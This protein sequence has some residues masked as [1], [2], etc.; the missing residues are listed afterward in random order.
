MEPE[1][2]I[3]IPT[4]FDS[5]YIVELALVTIRKYTTIPYK[6]V[7]GDAGVDEE[8]RDFLASQ[9]DVRVVACPDPLR[10]KD[11]LVRS[12]DTP[13]GIILHDDVQILREGWLRRRLEVMKRDPR[14]GI[15]GVLAP[16]YIYGW[17]RF[18]YRSPLYWRFFPLVMMIRREMQE[19]LDLWWGKIPGFDTGAI[20]YL[21]FLKQRKWRF[22][23]YKFNRDVLHLG[24]MTWVIRKK[25]QGEKM[26]RLDEFVRR[27]ELMLE[28]IKRRLREGD[29]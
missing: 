24:G 20:A 22:K 27:R 15:L 21:Q 3:L 28:E 6:V 23:R 18:F 25:V 29:Y 19:E 12:F 9:S 17:R 26:A 4:R 16:T 2:T 10:P 5:R 11:T 14:L 8:T 13:F 1:V 7:V